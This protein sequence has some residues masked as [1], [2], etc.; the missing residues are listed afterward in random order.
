MV[1]FRHV[2]DNKQQCKL[3]GSLTIYLP[4]EIT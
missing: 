1:L 3:E 2:A 4:L